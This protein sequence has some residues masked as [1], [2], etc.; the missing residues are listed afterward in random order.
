MTPLF[1]ADDALEY[2]GPDVIQANRWAF[3]NVVIHGGNV[4]TS[5]YILVIVKLSMKP[6][7]KDS[8]AKFNSKKVDRNKYKEYMQNNT[9]I[10]NLK[11]KTKEH[12]D[13]GQQLDETNN[14]SH[15][16]SNSSE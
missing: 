10:S 13:K 3:L 15:R 6:I 9:E 14:G 4:T 1:I 5:D 7:P 8:K 11:N 2:I 16:D 12:I